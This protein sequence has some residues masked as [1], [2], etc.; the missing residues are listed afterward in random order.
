MRVVEQAFGRL[1][2]RWQVT[3]H[4][5]LNNPESASQVATVAYAFHKFARGTTV[6]LKKTGCPK[7][8]LITMML[9][10]LLTTM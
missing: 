2:G 9:Y 4:S 6:P 8:L 7:M 10:V 5:N 1:K 3:A